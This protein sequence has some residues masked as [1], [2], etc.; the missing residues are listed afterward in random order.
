MSYFKKTQNEIHKTHKLGGTTH[1]IF[2]L[3]RD[4]SQFS[5]SVFYLFLDSM[6][7]RCLKLEEIAFAIFG[8]FFCFCLRNSAVSPYWRRHNKLSYTINLGKN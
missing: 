3:Q 7:I 6:M 1:T 5:V 2:A 8:C 4:F